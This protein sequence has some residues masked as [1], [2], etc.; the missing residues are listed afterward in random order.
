MIL[1]L[2]DDVKCLTQSLTSSAISVST[3]TDVCN[4]SLNNK[5]DDDLKSLLLESVSTNSFL[6]NQTV[7]LEASHEQVLNLK[8]EAKKE[9]IME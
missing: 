5:S 2:T 9:N 3:T 8:D 4:I 7:D 1:P 6:M